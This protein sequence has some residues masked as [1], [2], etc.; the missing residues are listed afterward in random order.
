MMAITEELKA[1]L[2]EEI[3][4]DAAFGYDLFR[5]IIR[6]AE[7]RIATA[8]Y[9]D[10]ALARQSEEI[11]ERFKQVD[12]RFEQVDQRLD[13]LDLRIESVKEELKHFI[14]RKLGYIGSR[15]GEDIE[16]TYR[17]FAQTIVT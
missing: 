14:D 16:S 9:L 2:I 3:N 6:G 7:D 13:Q 5:A 10:Q 11:N 4:E 1:A 17:N 8:A 12:R 15:W